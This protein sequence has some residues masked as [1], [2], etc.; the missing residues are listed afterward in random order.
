MH[1]TEEIWLH[2]KTAGK[3]KN[4]QTKNYYNIFEEFLLDPKLQ[5]RSIGSMVRDFV[6][7]ITFT[8]EKIPNPSYSR[9]SP[10][11]SFSN[12]TRTLTLILSGMFN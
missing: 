9:R 6:L 4:K 5:G 2:P 11:S 7:G 1:K 3:E 12:L 8:Q 10:P